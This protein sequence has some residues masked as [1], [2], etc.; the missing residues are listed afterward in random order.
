MYLYAVFVSEGACINFHQFSFSS[1][2]LINLQKK[3]CSLLDTYNDVWVF[4]LRQN[5]LNRKIHA[6]VTSMN[7]NK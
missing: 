6:K 3:L 7:G 4:L 1:S 2:I 5:L